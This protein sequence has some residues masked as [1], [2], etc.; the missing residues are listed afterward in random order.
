M[1]DEG[2]DLGV[3]R[4]E[5]LE[6][7][8]E[9]EAADPVGGHPATDPVTRFEHDHRAP[10]GLQVMGRGQ[11]GQTGSDDHDLGLLAA[12]RPDPSAQGPGDRS[13]GAP[14][15]GPGSGA[16]G[17]GSGAA[18]PASGAAGPG[19]GAAGPASVPLD[20]LLVI[21]RHRFNPNLGV[22]SRNRR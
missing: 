10:V 18:G 19:S 16:A 7:A 13:A 20:P 1:V 21:A 5:D 2:G 14:G 11:P 6:A 22:V 4:V 17:P 8:V 3:R 9:L 12:H 15:A